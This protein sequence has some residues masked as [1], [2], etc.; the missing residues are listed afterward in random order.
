MGFRA[1]LGKGVFGHPPFFTWVRGASW[2]ASAPFSPLWY[3]CGAS[4][5]SAASCA[6][7]MVV[8]VAAVL[9]MPVTMQ[10]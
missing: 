6:W 3:Y 8:A 2:P 5:L 10:A 7:A 1:G 9:V 4:V